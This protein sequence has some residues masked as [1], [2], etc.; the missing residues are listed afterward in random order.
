ML[1]H[2]K[3]EMGNLSILLNDKVR[4]QKKTRAI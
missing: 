1:K 3:V 4:R 2:R